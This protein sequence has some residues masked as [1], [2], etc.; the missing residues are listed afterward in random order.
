MARERQH[1]HRERGGTIGQ[2]GITSRARF[3]YIIGDLPDKEIRDS[4]RP[5][6]EDKDQARQA[7][8][9]LNEEHSTNWRAYEL[10]TG[11]R[12]LQRTV[13]SDRR[14][15]YTPVTHGVDDGYHGSK[16]IKVSL[17]AVG[18]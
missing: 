9:R 10:Q 17:K 5:L 7:A 3:H 6:L 18:K 14:W 2:E 4:G 8:A 1:Q 13:V 12:Y 11:Q 16:R 15:V